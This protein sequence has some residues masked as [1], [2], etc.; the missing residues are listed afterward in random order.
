[1]AIATILCVG[2]FDMNFKSFAYT[3]IART[4]CPRAF[5][6]FLIH[7]T[8]CFDKDFFEKSIYQILALASYVETWIYILGVI[9]PVL[10]PL[11]S[12]INKYKAWWMIIKVVRNLWFISKNTP[13]ML[14]CEIRH[15]ILF[16]SSLFQIQ[17]IFYEFGA[18]P[19]FSFILKHASRLNLVNLTSQTQISAKSNINIYATT[20]GCELITIL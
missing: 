10:C 5:F 6:Y 19:L 14:T 8:F 13:N 16:I 15:S 2:I 1:M 4:P 11:Y 12:S 20:K 18:W 9:T 17:C 7:G 3:K